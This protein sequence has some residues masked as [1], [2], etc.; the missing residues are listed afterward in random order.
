VHERKTGLVVEPRREDLAA[1]LEWLAANEDE[2][3]AFGL[4]GRDIARA[5]TW[6]AC[7]ERL[8]EAVA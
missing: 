8:L 3:H 7:V 2:A 6:D 1:A 4:A 5:V